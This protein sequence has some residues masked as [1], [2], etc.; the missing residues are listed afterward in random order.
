LDFA[1]E[2]DWKEFFTLAHISLYSL[3][4]LSTF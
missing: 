1:V 2:F 3:P 4:F